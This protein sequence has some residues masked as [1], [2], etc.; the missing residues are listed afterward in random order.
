[1]CTRF[2]LI[3]RSLFLFCVLGV[4]LLSA[5]FKTYCD[6]KHYCYKKYTCEFKSG[7][8]TSISFTKKEMTD[9]AIERLARGRD[10][11]AEYAKKVE[12][13][14]PDY[15]LSFVIDGEHRAV[16]IKNVIFDGIEAKPSIS[17]FHYPGKQ[18]G[19]IKDFQIEP[20]YVNL[21]LAEIIFPMPVRSVFNMKLSKGLVDKLKAKDKIKITLISIYDKEFVVET[22]NF[23]KKYDF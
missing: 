14:Y 1:M 16:N 20:P 6:K 18:L 10:F 21:K 9:V 4:F 3:I 13:F 11:N 8:I 17:V 12:A 23:I 7:S 2:I 5:E 19:E 22:D 15:S